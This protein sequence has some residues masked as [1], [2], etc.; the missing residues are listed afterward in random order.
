MDNQE[1]VKYIRRQGEARKRERNSHRSRL[2]PLY[3]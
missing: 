1:Q 3:I 2:A